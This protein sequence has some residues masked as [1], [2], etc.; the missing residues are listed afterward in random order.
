MCEAIK[1]WQFSSA[2][3]EYKI[4]S[5]HGGDEDWVAVIP[6]GVE[7]PYWMSSGFPF[8]ICEVSEHVLSDGRVVL[9][10]AHS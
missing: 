1:L 7:F 8:G 9:I 4:L 2:P 10:G 5:P 6:V 3:D